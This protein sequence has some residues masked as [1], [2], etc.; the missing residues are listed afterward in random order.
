MLGVSP[1]T[2]RSWERRHGYPRRGGR[3]GN[4]RLYE[5]NELEALRD[6]LDETGSISSAIEMARRRGRTAGSATRLVATFD[7]FDEAAADREMEESIAVRSV[8]RAVDELM[9]PAL[10]CRSGAPRPR[11][12]ARGRL[13]LGDRLAAPRPRPRAG[14][15]ARRRAS[16]CSRPIPARTSTRST[17]R[18]STWR[19]AA[20]GLRVLVLST[21]IAGERIGPATA[22]L[23]PGAV[24]IC[25]AEAGRELRGVA[26]QGVMRAPGS[27]RPTPTA[28]SPGARCALEP[29]PVAAA[30]AL[31]RRPGLA[32]QA[33]RLQDLA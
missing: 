18:R 31:A 24:V 10:E 22:A 12:R 6:A 23:R 8:E 30:A 19:C 7:R 28:P 17:P 4:H 33:V 11:G 29:S 26:L 3:P 13:P 25:G 16:C 9:L 32:A 15:L 20:L 2:L 21:E 27:G 5:L 1:S 14:R